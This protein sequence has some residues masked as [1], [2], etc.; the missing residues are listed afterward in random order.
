MSKEAPDTWADFFSTDVF[1]ETEKTNL[2]R[3][4][5]RESNGIENI[6]RTP[7]RRE[8][9]AHVT[10]LMEPEVTVAMLCQFVSAVQ[11]GA[12]LRLSINDTVYVGNHIPPAGGMGI[13][14]ALEELL[15]RDDDPYQSHIDYE[16]L[17]PFTDGN[18]RSGRALWLHRFG[19]AGLVKLFLTEF[20]YATLQ[21]SRQ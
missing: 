9:A 1:T 11:P 10:L 21:G 20:Y 4:F 17:H 5:V 16:T 2:I 7:S 6:F 19:P 8:I 13:A 18:G 14:Y 15:Q 12:R 3:R